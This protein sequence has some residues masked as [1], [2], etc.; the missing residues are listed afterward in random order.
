MLVSTGCVVDAD[1]NSG[2][3][4]VSGQC[5]FG[6]LV[7]RA[8]SDCAAGEQCLRGTCVAPQPQCTS[9]AQCPA[10]WL[11]QGGQCTPGGSTGSQC[12]GQQGA[13]SLSGS[14]TAVATCAA[15]PAGAVSLTQ[16]MA[17]IDDQLR[18]VVFN[19][20]SPDEGAVL[21]LE[22]CPG[23]VGTLSLGNGLVRASQTTDLRLYAERK[24]SS[25][26]LTFTRLAASLAG[27]FS[28]TLSAGGNVSGSFTLQ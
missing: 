15:I 18:L 2:Q 28:M 13:G 12:D 10:G 11:C 17:A 19:P 23:A 21:G 24:A 7:C 25:A 6:T 16:G 8:D 22:V 4:C 1:C 26:T 9:N 5:V 20:N 14:V 3:S 27:S